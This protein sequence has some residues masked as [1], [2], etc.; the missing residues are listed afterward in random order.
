MEETDEKYM[1]KV[2]MKL[3]QLGVTPTPENKILCMIFNELRELNN[4]LETL[5]SKLQRE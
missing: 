1:I 2:D 4:N 5:T 3:K